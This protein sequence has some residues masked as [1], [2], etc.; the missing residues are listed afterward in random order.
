MR[1]SDIRPL[2][3]EEVAG[4]NLLDFFKKNG[5]YAPASDFAIATGLQVLKITDP[6]NNKSIVTGKYWLYEEFFRPDGSCNDGDYVSTVSH[7]Y[8]IDTTPKYERTPGIRLCKPYDNIAQLQQ[9]HTI[10]YDDNNNPYILYGE[11]P[12]TIADKDT[13]KYLEKVRNSITKTNKDV[14]KTDDEFYVDI[15]DYQERGRELDCYGFPVYKYK[16]KKYFRTCAKECGVQGIKYFSDKTKI[17][18]YKKY[19]FEV[20]PVKWFIDT[21]SKLLITEKILQSG[22]NYNPMGSVI[23]N[24]YDDSNLRRFIERWMISPMREHTHNLVNL[25]H[26][27]NSQDKINADKLTTKE[28]KQKTDNKKRNVYGFDYSKV[29]EEEIMKGAIESKISVFLHGLPGDGK[30]ARVKELDPTCEIIYLRNTNLESLTGKSVYNELTGEMIDVAPAWYTNIIEKSKKEPDKIHLLFFDELTNV[31]PSV[32]GAAFNIILDREVNGIWRIPDNVRIVA[33]GNDTKDS[34]AA[35][36]LAEPLFD[37]FAHVYIKTS[38]SDWLDWAIK[39]DNDYKRVDYIK[40]DFDDIH[41]AIIDF[42][43]DMGEEYL[44]SEYDGIMPNAT[45]RKWEMAS[46]ILYKT[47]KPEM[48]RSLIGTKY[49]DD[50]INYCS[51][52]KILI[53]EKQK[54]M[55]R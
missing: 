7:G 12:Q 22:I 3:K 23:C 28:E 31:M 54:G 47:N 25:V 51:N 18:K 34:T 16:N 6:I 33:A 5:I 29:S 52:K 21:N 13:S 4:N 17:K 15:C 9:K 27:L 8:G 44:R 55:K 32:Q 1:Y 48:L 10:Y 24:L 41:P 49:T 11:Y 53:K 35:S 37:R 20:E 38:V 46:R 43:E 2:K 26:N 39:P 50:F 19:W 45:P 30:S 42:I 40:E 36:D 14:V